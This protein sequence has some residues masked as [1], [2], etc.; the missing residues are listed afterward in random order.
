MEDLNTNCH[1]LRSIFNGLII[2]GFCWEEAGDKEAYIQDNE[3][4][5]GRLIA[6]RVMQAVMALQE[7]ESM[8]CVGPHD[9]IDE[10]GGKAFQLK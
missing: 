8:L 1:S 3:H 4:L 7:K 10:P 5:Q 2:G 6:A 9:F